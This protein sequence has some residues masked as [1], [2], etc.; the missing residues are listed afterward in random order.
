MT[1][2]LAA[3]T[4]GAFVGGTR[5]PVPLVA[6]SFDVRIEGGLAVVRTSRR[7]RNAEAASI[8]A[9]FTFPVP[10]HA[11][12]FAL[13]VKVD[14]RTLVARAQSSA[15]A[16]DTYEDAI[17]RG[18]T[19][20][21]HEELLRGVH[22]LSVGHIPPDVEIETVSE[23]VAALV[24][25]GGRGRLRIP[26]TVGDIYGRSPLPA[27][28][29]LVHRGARQS[30]DLVVS[31]GD[32]AVRLAG[33]VVGGGRVCVG[34]DAPIDLE[35]D[36]WA[37]R[38]LVGRAADGRVVVLRA[39]PLVPADDPVD[40]ALL[41][42]HSGSM[43]KQ[44][45]SGS[46]AQ[47]SKHEAVIRALV[48]MADHFER[49]DK[50]EVWEFDNSL[51]RVG[52][53]SAGR[54]RGLD[55]LARRLSAPAGGT[56]IG[57]AL[58]GVLAQSK[59]RDVLILTDGKSHA[60]DVQALARAGRRVNVV[61]IGEDS[62][63]A[64]VGHLAAL[65]GGEIF[66]AAGDD[67]TEIMLAALDSFRRPHE[68]AATIDPAIERVV[69][70]RGNVRLS[71]S[72]QAAEAVRPPVKGSL[73]RAAA[74]LAVSLVLPHLDKERAAALAEEEGLV[75]HLTSL[76]LVNEASATQETVPATRKVVLPEPAVLRP[77]RLYSRAPGV[78]FMRLSAERSLKL[79]EPI[80]P[81]W[82]AVGLVDW[83]LD[84]TGLIAGEFSLVDA[85]AANA[86][87]EAAA[88]PEVVEV[89]KRH[90]I[91]PMALVLGLMAL[92][93]RPQSRSAA[94]IARAILG[95]RP[96]PELAALGP[97]IGLQNASTVRFP[98]SL[99]GLPTLLAKLARPTRRGPP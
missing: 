50:V 80:L 22:M 65:T 33:K 64:N 55:A 47:I 84:P 49:S 79:P 59:A 92:L 20:V 54:C 51:A 52:A 77:V 43:A 93:G 1:D 72:W 53:T 2:P 86:I 45:A 60:L 7:F 10:V 23:W 4:A 8:E 16:R 44:C 99:F 15:K 21:L 88:L 94:R 71:A 37:A 36:G 87:R 27:S 19:S 24:H 11:T 74:A 76:V 17:E 42:D 97:V 95:V 63:E 31:S 38:D 69:V 29:D 61:L 57:A 98:K 96:A 78:M 26:L 81:L 14:G 48:A 73:G 68:V 25:V 40:L 3:F 12:L 28:D 70:D 46:G 75:T 66:V 83:G 62:L 56:E 30:A 9:T 34:L 89:A 41:V 91:D 67:L 5:R 18:K 58:S 82:R 32:G 90:G 39:E 13:E 35:V 85:R 6:T